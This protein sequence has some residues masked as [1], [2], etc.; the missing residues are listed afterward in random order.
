VVF[1]LKNV[2]EDPV[3]TIIK[4]KLDNALPPY[5]GSVSGPKPFFDPA[6]GD[7]SRELFKE[8]LALRKPCKL[9]GGRDMV[10]VPPSNG[11]QKLM[12]NDGL[13]S[14]RTAGAYFYDWTYEVDLLTVIKIRQVVVH[15]A[16]KSYS[17]D[18]Q[19]T[20]SKDGKEWEV[21]GSGKPQQGGQFVHLFD[22]VEARYVRVTSLAPNGEGQVGGQM[23][24]LELEVFSKAIYP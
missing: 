18:Y 10:E 2:V 16:E 4:I 11:K 6:R 24:V 23:W 5:A 14:T 12:G 20:V 19:V 15:M 3:S 13:I 8:N 9:L 22:P 1:D 17:T 7:K 21:V